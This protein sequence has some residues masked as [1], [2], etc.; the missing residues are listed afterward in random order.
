VGDQITIQGSASDASGISHTFYELY[1]GS[2]RVGYIYQGSPGSGLRSSYTWTVP[3]SI[4]GHTIDGS[5]YRIKMV[6]WDASSNNNSNADYSNG[7]LALRQPDTTP[8]TV[9]LSFPDNGTFAVGQSINIQGTASDAS[10]I[11]HVQIELY[12][13]GTATANRVGI[14]LLGDIGDGNRTSFNWTVPATIAGHTING[15]DYKIKWIAFDNSSNHNAAGDY[16]T[17]NLTIQPPP[18]TTPP[19]VN[20]SFPDNG[21]FTVGQSIN[22]QGTASDASGI[23]HVQIELYKGG[24]ATAN[25]VGII[26]QGNIGDGNRTSYS[27]T[28]PSEIDEHV[29]NGADYKIKW[30]AWD[31]SPNNNAAGDYSESNVTIQPQ[32]DLRVLGID[33][34]HHQGVIN[35]AQVAAT[36]VQFAYVKATEGSGIGDPDPVG[37]FALDSRFGQNAPGADQAGLIVGAYHYARPDLGNSALDEATWFVSQAHSFVGAGYLPP[38][39]DVESEALTVPSATLSVWVDT[40]TDEVERLTG[41]RPVLYASQANLGYIDQNPSD[42]DLWVARYYVNGQAFPQN[43]SPGDVSPWAA[44]DWDVWQY[45]SIGAVQGING[46]VDLNVFNGDYSELL[47]WVNA[48]HDAEPPVV[49]SAAANKNVLEQGEDIQFS[50]TATDNVAVDHVSLY[51]YQNGQH[52]DTS[53]YGVTGGNLDGRIALGAENIP[54]NGSGSF[55]WTVFNSLPAGDYRIKV[56]AWDTAGNPSSGTLPGGELRYKWIDFSVVAAP[57]FAEVTVLGNG[58]DVADDDMSPSSADGTDFGSVAQGAAVISRS[59]TVRNDGNASLTLGSV[60]VP[61][62]F[63]LTNPLN[64]QLDPGQSD[65]F[66]V[67]LD[68]AVAGTKTG[69]ISFT[70]NDSN[71]NPFNFSISGVVAEELTAPVLSVISTTETTATL[72]WTDS[73]IEIGYHIF[74]DGAILKSVPQD[75]TNTI[76]TD[77]SRNTSYDFF[78]QAYTLGFAQTANSNIVNVNTGDRFEANDSFATATDFGTLSKRTEND[79]SIHTPQNDDYYR[80]AA[81]HSGTLNVDLAFS[82]N[83]GDINL[84][85]FDASQIELGRSSGTLNTEHVS[86]PV[87]AGQTYYVRV[88]GYNGATNPDYDLV[89]DGPEAPTDISLSNST[90]NENTDTSTAD[91]LIGSL[92]T[93]DP[94]QGDTHTYT[95]VAG[96]GSI[97]NGSFTISGGDV[98]I[99]NLSTSDVDAGDSHTY[100]LVN[101]S[102]DADNGS[103]TISGNQLQ[104]KRNTVLDHEAHDTYGVRVRVTDGGG[105]AFEK[106]FVIAVADI[107]DEAP[108]VENQTLTLAMGGT[109]ILGVTH[110]LASDPDSNDASLVFTVKGLPTNGQLKK[111]GTALAVDDTF[112]QADVTIGSISYTNNGASTASDSFTF[113][114]RDPAGN[115]TDTET[116]SITIASVFLQVLSF[117]TTSSGFVVQLSTDLEVSQLNLY[118]QGG[119]FGAADVTVMGAN[120]GEVRGSLVVDPATREVAFIKTGGPLEPDTYTVT[121]KSGAN[122]FQETNGDLLDGNSDGTPGDDFV[123]SFEIQPPPA[124]T[125]TVSIPDFT[126]GYGQPVNLP[127]NDLSS[128]LPLMLSDGL[129]LSGLDLQLHYDPAVLEISGFALASD[130]VARGGQAQLTFLSPGRAILTVDTTDSLGALAGP[131]TL[132]AFVARVPDDAL[133]GAKHILDIEDLHV[134][135]NGPNLDEVPSVADDAIHIAA[136]LGD[137]NG[138]GSYNSPDTTLVRRIIGQ[139]NT[140]F[141]AYQLADP[142]LLADITLNDRIQGNDTTSIRRLI[143]QVPV[144]NVPPLPTGLTPPPASGLDPKIFIPQDVAGLPGET[145]SVPVRVEVTEP[146]G[147]TISG[148]ELVIEF[149]PTKF[150]VTG[151]QLGALFNGSDVSGSLT[152][153]IS[154]ILI[155]TADSFNGSGPFAFNTFGDLVTL[156]FAIES[157]APEGGSAINLRAT[158]GPTSTAMFDNDLNDLIIIPAPT[159]SPTD[160]VDGILSVNSV[161]TDPPA[162]PAI[163]GITQDTGTPGDGITSDQTLV[164]F[165][166]AEAGSTVTVTR[167]GSGVIGTVTADGSGDW[168]FDYTGT[169]LAEGSHDFTATATD[170]AGNTGAA[171]G[172]LTVVVDISVPAAP[173]IAGITQ[174]T[175]TPGD[176]ITSDTTLVIAGAAEANSSVEVFRDA[177]SIGAATADDNGDWSFDFSGTTLAEGS[178]VLTAVAADLAGNVSAASAAFAVTIDATAPASSTLSPADDAADVAVGTDLVITFG[179]NI[180]KGAGNILIKRVDDDSTVETIDVADSTVTISGAVATINPTDLTEATAYYVQ[181]ASGAFVDAAGNDFAGIDDKTT[182]N[183]ATAGAASPV[184]DV[185]LVPVDSPTQDDSNSLPTEV[186]A[187][188]VGSTYFV[189]IWIQE[190]HPQFDGSVG[191]QV[192]VYYETEFS[193]AVAVINKDF[194]QFPSG[195]IDD[196]AGRVD[197]LGGGKNAIG[198]GSEPLWARLGYIE[199]VATAIGLQAFRLEPGAL[200][201]ALTSGGPVEWDAVDLTDVA[202]LEIVAASQFDVTVV[203]EPT[204][205]DADGEVAALPDSAEGVHEWEPFY[206]EVWGSTDG[207]TFD[208]SAARFDFAYDTALT[209][210]VAIEEGPGFTLA[211]GLIDDVTGL[212]DD[213]T[214]TAEKAGLG[215]DQFV[216]LARIRFEPTGDDQ[217]E[218]DEVNH[219]VGPYDLA[220]ALVDAEVTVEGATAPPTLGDSPDTGMWAVPYDIDDDNVIGFGDFSFLVPNFAKTR[221]DGGIVFPPGHPAAAPLAGGEGEGSAAGGSGSGPDFAVFDTAAGRELLAALHVEGPFQN[222]RLD[223]DV[224]NDNQVTPSDA[225][226]VIN[227][228]NGATP[229]TV[230]LDVNG[231]GFATPLDALRVINALNR[232]GGQAS[233]VEGESSAT[234]GSGAAPVA[235]HP[236]ALIAEDV[237]ASLS[238]PSR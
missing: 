183:F 82:H 199:M 192:D 103:F 21:T 158:S 108:V 160:S 1:K 73:N 166:T 107:D 56:V 149:D 97:D 13:G 216:L 51:L 61:T 191:G 118:D 9:N 71:E 22:I 70:T 41:V 111:D 144:A 218:V 74:K 67:Q 83:L 228:L 34:S 113:T 132:G 65:T 114:V 81:E 139:V 57:A 2:S 217:A 126:R 203:R 225:L 165:G 40:W 106:A 69:Q 90:I 182:W 233:G 200:Q 232:E 79:L 129:G 23:S 177:A 214:L 197:D 121:F 43:G 131:M 3:S 175:G 8:P 93:T 46:N 124:N 117:S 202:E 112:T 212:V 42:T 60:S 105:L 150:T 185:R 201:F 230:F 50:W 222:G 186:T 147:I 130:V 63:T 87:V 119:Q 142:V 104:V 145:V 72:S 152:Q 52:I 208:L 168:S 235:F 143:G 77:L 33:V 154:G 136:F 84:Y 25:R 156:D 75:S 210:A 95:L 35:W 28:V 194:D 16:S 14:I 29:I 122:G 76:V 179:E 213:V 164:L 80:L 146:A 85:V 237:D 88:N 140:G 148:F 32:A 162:A 58:Q 24:T 91:V 169:T 174:D 18:D 193:D 36:D 44:T 127:A 110:L 128:G 86:I 49:T 30:I 138:S 184:V 64:S 180:T 134:F 137:A 96:T 226:R 181:V 171:S 229:T 172:N 219:V 238:R 170:A 125:V 205:T 45:T 98:L 19:T 11:S 133:Y 101:G 224:N 167:V 62:G 190:S 55:D 231:D 155:Y 100:T 99:G 7:Y 141:G 12:K 54:S 4:S 151:S 195:T 109:Q 196:A 188:A 17:G 66:S 209:T 204:P 236:V 173:A 38:V 78:V 159:N 135:D 211:G 48:S 223:I 157:D 31:A 53:G 176:G 153:P 163:A 94:D 102:G 187:V 206:V 92:S 26:L 198:L 15:N 178:Y 207:T 37:S 221:A 123:T 220:L 116:F 20:L 59:F 189:E 5:D 6:V 161:D 120:V 47:A 215:D 68:T 27:W 234:F 115:E 39:V 227:V 10:G 89:I